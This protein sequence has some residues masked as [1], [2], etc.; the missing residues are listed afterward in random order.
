MMPFLRCF[1][2]DLTGHLEGVQANVY[3]YVTCVYVPRCLVG[4]FSVFPR[5]IHR[6]L[7]A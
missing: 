4:G 3:M 2:M 7:G 6:V 5:E 1:F